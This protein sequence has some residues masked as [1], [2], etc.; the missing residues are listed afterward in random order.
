MTSV[1]TGKPRNV[2]VLAYY[3][4][5]LGL[6]GV[7]RVA[8]FVK[9]LPDSGWNPTVL[10]AEPGGYFAF[11]EDLLQELNARDIPI[12]RTMSL[13][14]TRV[15]G[16]STSVKLPSEGRRQMLSTLSQWVFLPDNKAGWMP[17]AYRKAASLLRSGNFDA[18]LSTAPP[19]SSHLVA[20]KLARKF[21][22]PL[23]LD[24]RD[25]WLGNPR[26]VYPTRLH[27]RAHAALERRAGGQADAIVTINSVI[28]RAIHDRLG[29]PVAV[30]PQG[31][32]PDD[33]PTEDSPQVSADHSPPRSER[34]HFIYT[35]VFYDRQTPEPFLKGLAELIRQK[36]QVAKRIRATFVGLFPEECRPLLK[37]L[38]LE[39]VVDIL[40]YEKHREAMSRVS[41]ADVAWLTVGEGPG[42]HGISTGKLFAY[43]G[44][45]VPILGIVPKGAAREMLE[46]YGA[47]WVA[48]PD[49][50]EAIYETL[51]RILEAWEKGSLPKPDPA[52]VAGYDRRALT[53]KLADV[54]DRVTS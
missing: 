1:P 47:S 46:A 42:Q 6:S 52:F 29:V 21:R 54:L 12:H 5:P 53:G 30:I 8:K 19:Y 37:E 16:K 7:Q 32:D 13:D 17:F 11:D 43:A 50:P 23:V 41:E 49:E 15:F 4:P 27:K 2:L 40:P 28:G 39:K 35:G 33:Y 14:P 25:D 3:F 45:S 10:T 51:V 26:H 31:F 48:H 44:A 36:P 34:L 38:A 9:Y 22:L 20:A 18:I 24:Y